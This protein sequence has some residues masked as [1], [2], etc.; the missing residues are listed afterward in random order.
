MGDVDLEADG[1]RPM[2]E[3][4]AL[5]KDRI[6][7]LERAYKDIQELRTQADG[8]LGALGGARR[9]AREAGAR[10]PGVRGRVRDPHEQSQEGVRGRPRPAP[11]GGKAT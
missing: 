3:V 4:E 8:L 7:S 2:T 9:D 6:A 11:L 5:Y 1:G 10:G